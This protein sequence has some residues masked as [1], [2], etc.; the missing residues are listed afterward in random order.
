MQMKIIQNFAKFAVLKLKIF[1]NEISLDYCLNSYNLQC[2]FHLF[3][4]GMSELA[5][6]QQTFLGI[7]TH[8]YT[9]ST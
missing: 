1:I 7:R 6:Q 2:Y 3:L 9:I 4:Q 5:Q 8:I